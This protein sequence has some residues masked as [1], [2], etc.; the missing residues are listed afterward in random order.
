VLAWTCCPLL[1]RGPARGAVLTVVRQAVA[2][3]L[4]SFQSKI[5]HSYGVL[6]K[7]GNPGDD[8]FVGKP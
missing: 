5:S 3:K 8:H 7:L 2:I 4:P 1:L 6:V